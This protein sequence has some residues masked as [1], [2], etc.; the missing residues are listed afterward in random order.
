MAVRG[1]IVRCLAMVVCA[2]ALVPAT[3]SAD[4]KWWKHSL[5]SS[6]RPGPD[7]LYAPRP[8]SPQ[9]ENKGV[10]RARPILIS[11]ASAYRDGEFLYQDFLYDDH[12]ARGGARD[13]G[14][15]RT[16]IDSF[17]VPSGTYTY[18]TDPVYAGNAADIV[19]LRVKPLADSTAFRLTLNTLKD[20]SLVAA[21]IAIGDSATPQPFP[22]GANASA[23]AQ[24]FL[25]VHGNTADML[26]AATGTP[27]PEQPNVS[28]DLERRQIEVRVP[29]TV[30]DPGT[31]VVRLAAGV[32]L[33]DK[34]NDRYLIPQ[35][36]ADATHPGGSTLATPTAFFNA[37]FRYDEPIQKP[38]FT[39]L[40][41]PGWWRDRA[42]G[43]SLAGGNLTPFHAD[44][45]FAKLAADVDDDMPGQR[46]GVPQTGPMNRI[47]VSRFETAQGTDYSNPCLTAAQTP[48]GVT[49]TAFNS[50]CRGELTGRLQPYAIY[51]PPQEPADGY[52]L[53]LLLHALAGNYNQFLG[54]RHTAQFAARGGGSIV[55][56]PEARGPDGFYFGHPGA[57]VFEVWAD[58]ARRYPLAP[59]RTAV[60][61]YSMGGYGTW[62]LAVQFPDLFARAQPTVGP[63]L[64]GNSQ[65]LTPFGETVTTDVLG[66]L[67]HVPVLIWLGI[68][69]T[70]VPYLF[71]KPNAD[72]LD[73]LGYRYELDSFAPFNF[74]IL[75]IPVPD[76][77]FF[78][79]ND[80]Y[81]PAAD[82]LD[83]AVAKRD[84]AHVTYAYKRSMD[85]PQVG[86]SGGHAYW[87]S[88]VKLRSAAGDAVGTIDV[89]SHGFGVG[90]PPVSPTQTG[91]GVLTGGATFLAAPF[92]SQLRTWGDPPVT[93][94]AK[95]L[96][97]T[98]TNVSAVTI[99]AN[100][101]RV[102]CKPK[103]N[104][105][106][107]GKLKI[108]LLGCHGR[109][110]NLKRD[111]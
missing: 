42:Q 69:D 79:L 31:G 74:S 75:G 60:A 61:G 47:L 16:P 8:H 78:A 30:W 50:A 68:G 12:G 59:R 4:S 90:D 110:R 2:T 103:L 33:W 84:P 18:P 37:A 80:Q 20:P 15:P 32:G 64:L 22:H 89:R 111:G 51:V 63:P 91:S 44:V 108:K 11:G 92:T 38:D 7:V 71:A 95:Q 94:V 98:A 101:A 106:S 102:G 28:V 41:D 96:D 23:P 73:R 54:S 40:L 17:S 81:Q 72:E 85:S 99:D 13:P 93:A 67:R 46:G 21:T 104:V 57:D 34:V 10:W 14:D 100:R 88:G 26:D 109:G 52:R 58:V 82:F 65:T 70:T 1:W 97:I 105:V 25:T 3:A 49:T 43:N 35:A 24:W 36:A 27:A 76:H 9:L 6:K 77:I 48:N 86:L 39:V 5:S 55:I 53:T 66:S 87:V 62:K 83:D 56:T 29:H 45:D 19:E 107:D